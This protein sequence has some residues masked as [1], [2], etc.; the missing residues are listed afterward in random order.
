MPASQIISKKTVA[1]PIFTFDSDSFKLKTSEEEGGVFHPKMMA[2]YSMPKRGKST[3]LKSVVDTWGD[4]SIVAWDL[5]DTLL[6]KGVPR[7]ELPNFA[8]LYPPEQHYQAILTWWDEL[9]DRAERRQEPFS[10]ET[11]VFAVDTADK[12]YELIQDADLARKMISRGTPPE[13]WKYEFQWYTA[14]YDDIMKRIYRMKALKQKGYFVVLNFHALPKTVK[15]D[16][17]NDR[18]IFEPAVPNGLRKAIEFDIDMMIYLKASDGSSPN[19]FVTY[20]K[21]DTYPAGDRTGKLPPI[22]YPTWG[23]LEAVFTQGAEMGKDPRFA[24]KI[25]QMVQKQAKTN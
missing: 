25:K 3:F 7:V 16:D 19:F 23:A 6:E 1:A 13:K 4:K 14:M 10:S 5:E 8:E 24:P 2:I 18:Q 22:M 21:N 12:L 11:R 20:S 17:G 15:D 9:I